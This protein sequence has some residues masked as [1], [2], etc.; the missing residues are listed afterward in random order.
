MERLGRWIALMAWTMILL[1]L[2]GCRICADCEDLAYPAYGGA[3]ERTRR[4]SG[5]VGS[6]FDPAGAQSASLT[7]RDQPPT[8]DALERDRQEERNGGFDRFDRD[9]SEDTPDSTP[10]I[11]EDLD[12]LLKRKLD[13]IQDKDEQRL[14]DKGLDDIN[15]S[16]VPRKVSTLK[17]H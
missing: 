3:W 13:D 16:I 2:S 10:R 6:L 4:D 8:P 12:D 17:L 7:D 1:P 11:Q 14:R 15:I 5:R 9:N